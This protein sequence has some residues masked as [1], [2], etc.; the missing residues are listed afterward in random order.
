M[1]KFDD[2][3]EL[4]QIESE[5]EDQ[6]S[7][8]ANF[9]IITYP[10]DYTIWELSRK[11]DKQEIIIP[12]FQRQFVW[13]MPQATRLIESFLMGLPVPAIFLY[14]KVSDGAFQLIDGQQR[15]KS[16][17]YFFKGDFEGGKQS[18]KFKLSKLSENSPWYNK[19]FEE[20]EEADQGKLKNRVL[21]AFV[22]RQVDPNDD[23]SIFHIFERLNTGGTALSSQEVRNCV[24]FGDFNNILKNEFN[25][26][27][28]WRLILGKEEPDDRMKDVELILRC[29]A[30][31]EF[32]TY[33]RPLKE[34]LNKYMSTKMYAG[35][36]DIN[37]M[38]SIF[39]SF[40][41]IVTEALDYR[42][43]RP[44]LGLNPS[45]L[46]CCFVGYF[47]N[48]EMD[49]KEFRVKYEKLQKSLKEK[50][51]ISRGTTDKKTVENRCNL[52]IEVF[53]NA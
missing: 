10:A 1:K 43:F 34:H 51:Y 37:Q 7:S 11:L 9:E 2:D 6:F 36:K 26:I 22:I 28:E 53:K 49:P 16:I 24:Y 46:D 32:E 38:K 45:F 17:N 21:R 52:A 41:K 13:R 12:G 5:E 44:N 47:N 50:G 30:L 14:Q 23:T 33:E 42:P 39:E 19:T 3:F 25:N 31:I 15:L 40:C 8:P 29:L 4:E 48:P 35:K 18:R 20:L 27:S